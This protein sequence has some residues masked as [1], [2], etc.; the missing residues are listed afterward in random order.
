MNCQ[1]SGSRGWQQL[2]IAPITKYDRQPGIG[3]GSIFADPIQSIL[4]KQYREVQ[5]ISCGS[6][7]GRYRCRRMHPELE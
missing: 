7:A 6:F 2:P 5:V 1:E 3:H 4:R